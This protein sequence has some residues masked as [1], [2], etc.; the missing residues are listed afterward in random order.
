MAQVDHPKDMKALFYTIGVCGGIASGKSTLTKTLKV[1]GAHV[2]DADK[3]GHS[4]YLPGS[5]TLRLLQG[6]FGE[7]IVNKED[8]TL[9][10]KKLGSI[11]FS[12]KS[13]LEKLNQIVWP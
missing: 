7:D 3:V 6:A 9:N 11:V 8:G 1:M 2:I 5:E 4:C 13:E 12:D 10:R